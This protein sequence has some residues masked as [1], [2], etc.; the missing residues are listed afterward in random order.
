MN[1]LPSSALRNKKN[2]SM[3]VAINLVKEGIAQACVSAGNTGALMATSRFVLKTI[4]GVDRPAIIAMLPSEKSDVYVLDLGANVDCTPDQLF[5]FAVMGS[6]LAEAVKNIEKPRIALLNVG[7]EEIKG[8]LQVKETAELLKHAPSL[9]YIGFIEGS[10]IFKGEVDVVVCDG[11][12][13]NVALKSLEGL[14]R[15][16]IAQIKGVF[17]ESWFTK[18]CALAVS[19]ILKRLK[20]RLDPARYNGASL[21]GL[22]GIV[23]KSHGGADA[24]SFSFAITQAVLEVEKNVPKR[25][26]DKVAL[27]LENMS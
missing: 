11:F 3:R 27:L 12:V 2:S 6:V 19:S 10:D 4:P 25:I 24:K 13:G 20:K 7:E 23:I 17:Q 22:N 14:S 21:I 18:L 16:M 1:E 15:Y 5:Q 26:H 8:N 9:N